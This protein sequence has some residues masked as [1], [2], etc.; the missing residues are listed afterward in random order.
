MAK[1]SSK[2]KAKSKK[3][4]SAWKMTVNTAKL[5]WLHKKPFVILTLIYGFLN[6]LLVKGFAGATNVGEL[7]DQLSDVFSGS[8]G[9]L[10]S[11]LGVFV[12]L[13]GSSGNTSSATGGAYQLFLGIL[14]SLAIIW[15]LRQLLQGAVTV[16]VRD[17]FYNGM[18]PLVPF[19]GV[20]IIVGFQFIPMLIGSSIYGIVINNGIAVHMIEKV[21]WF[22]VFILLSSL[23]LLFISSSLIALYIVTLPNMTPFKALRSAKELVKGRRLI[24]IR[25]LL[26]MPL[27]L[28]IGAAILMLPIII[29]ATPLAQWVFFLLTMFGLVAV[30]A[31]MYGLYRELL[32]E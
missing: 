20:L 11:G 27:A 17:A 19:I 32:G 16:K 26:W 22:V 15:M 18:Y 13:L 1:K 31:Y 30:H 24:V 21:L 29:W 28:L 10:A 4:P 6:L 14:T 23:T 8:F 12:I 2:S 25:K 5:I 3:L 7:K 9:S